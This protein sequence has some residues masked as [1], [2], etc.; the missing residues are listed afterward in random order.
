MRRYALF[1]T[2]CVVVEYVLILLLLVPG[3]V[4]FRRR[5]F[6]LRRQ[7]ARPDAVASAVDEAE[8]S[9]SWSCKQVRTPPHVARW[10]SS[11]LPIS[12]HTGIPRTSSDL[13]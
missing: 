12:P 9:L 7:K 1:Q 6:F 8:R 2:I 10:L 3:M 11:H 4:F 5:L 13:P